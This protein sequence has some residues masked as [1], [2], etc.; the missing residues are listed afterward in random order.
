MMRRFS[1]W[2]KGLRQERRATVEDYL[3]ES[4]YTITN[5][6]DWQIRDLKSAVRIARAA[7]ESALAERNT[8]T[9]EALNSHLLE[10]TE[11]IRA[12]ARFEFMGGSRE[13]EAYRVLHDNYMQQK[14]RLQ[15]M[16]HDT[17]EM[18]EEV[19]QARVQRYIDQM[20]EKEQ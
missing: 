3:P 15:F 14:A 16:V 8:C 13:T 18:P 11:A 4:I 5:A 6:T 1:D 7:L 17:I 12:V 10:L 20:K 9:P 19:A 2:Y